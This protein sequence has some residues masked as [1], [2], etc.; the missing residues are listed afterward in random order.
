M[1]VRRVGGVGGDA[2]RAPCAARAKGII[3]WAF[4]LPKESDVMAYEEAWVNTAQ[5]SPCID[6]FAD[7]EMND[8]IERL[9]PVVK[10]AVAAV[11]ADALFAHEGS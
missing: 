10:L 8:I 9:K 4:G 7:Q 1:V 2:R 11:S 5:I 3:G 6:L